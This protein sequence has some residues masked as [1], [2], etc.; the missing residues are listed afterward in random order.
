MHVIDREDIM[1]RTTSVYLP[2]KAYHMLNRN[3]VKICSLDPNVERLAFT[4][5]VYLD[6]EGN[7]VG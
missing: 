4:V 2:Y 6:L 5:W 3:L 1:R 7:I